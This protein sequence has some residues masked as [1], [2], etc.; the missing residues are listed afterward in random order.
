MAATHISSIVVTNDQQ[1]CGILTETDLVE[2]VLGQ[3]LPYDTAVERVMTKHVATIS[4]FAYYYD[5]L[6][7]MIERG[8]KHLPVVDDGK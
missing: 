2:R 5:A 4:R 8:V 1:L 6:A 3:S 7:M